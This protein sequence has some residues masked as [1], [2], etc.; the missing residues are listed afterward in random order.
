MWYSFSRAGAFHHS[1]EVHNQDRVFSHTLGDLTCIALADGASAESCSG[2]GAELACRTAGLQLL[3]SFERLYTAPSEAWIR[4]ELVSA[5]HRELRIYSTQCPDLDGEDRLASTL[6]ALCVNRSDG[7]Y[8]CLHTGDGL[9]ACTD[10]KDIRTISFPSNGIS[11]QFTTLTVSDE[12]WEKTQVHRG[13]RPDASFFLMSD[14]CTIYAW[15]GVRFRTTAFRLLRARDWEGFQQYLERKHPTD[16][17]SFI[18]A[19]GW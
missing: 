8:I 5:V 6:I 13:C 3:C 16:D 12:C 7:R 18:A 9:A 14:G 11:P 15:D 10:G 4:H 2:R 17:Y 19:D 1:L